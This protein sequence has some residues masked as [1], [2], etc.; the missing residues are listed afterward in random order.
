MQEIKTFTDYKLSLRDRILDTAMKD[1]ARRGVKA[2]KMDDIAAALA[3]SKR[4]LYEIF[5]TKEQVIFEGLKRY[6]RLKSEE[7]AAYASA[8]HHDV[9][10]IIIFIYRRR[11]NDS[12]A[13]N[14][15]FY[16][17][18]SK[19]PQIVEYLESQK[20]RRQQDFIQFMQR[21]VDEGF[22][23][24]E[25]NYTIISR[26]FEALGSYMQQTRLYYKYSFKEL[27]FN[28]L[29]VTLRGFCTAKGISKL[30]QFFAANR[31]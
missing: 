11:I 22:F 21:G 29:F 4:T 8:P 19:Y 9:L 26:V 28:M 3:I 14:P 6:H 15:A 25:I 10:D 16:D 7:L 5:D 30:D 1:F 27:F 31:P 2:V 23:R 24:N 18:I 13:L 17:E 20:Q 12:S